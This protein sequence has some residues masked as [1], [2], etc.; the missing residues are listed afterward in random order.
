MS[1]ITTIII[2]KA[3][4]A[5]IAHAWSLRKTHPTFRACL[6]GASLGKPVNLALLRSALFAAMRSATT[7]NGQSM[8]RRKDAEA[9]ERAW[10]RLPG[11][12]DEVANLEQ[13]AQLS[14]DVEALKHALQVSKQHLDNQTA[15]L[16]R[17]SA[18]NREKHAAL[19]YALSLLS[20]EQRAQ[21]DGFID[22]LAA[23]A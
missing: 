14:A 10:N 2:P 16:E 18:A 13:H 3:D 5:D 11:K 20:D 17:T 23:Q 19:N 8:G 9:I 6:K 21:V 4:R 12:I 22:G 15:A 7:A 1:D